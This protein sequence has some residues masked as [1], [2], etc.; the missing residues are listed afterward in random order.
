LEEAKGFDWKAFVSGSAAHE[1]LWCLQTIVIPV[2]PAVPSHCGGETTQGSEGIGFLAI[3]ML[4]LASS[5]LSANHN[6]NP[7]LLGSN[8]SGDSRE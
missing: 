2:I 4:L 8:K 3:Q 6:A 7:Y 5:I 1:K